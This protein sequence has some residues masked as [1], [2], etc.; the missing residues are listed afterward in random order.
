MVWAVPEAFHLHAFPISGAVFAPDI[1]VARLH[2]RIVYFCIL[3]SNLAVERNANGRR[4]CAV[5]GVLF[6]RCH[7]LT[8][9]LAGMRIDH[10]PVI[11][12]HVS[13][14]R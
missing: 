2:A 9:V 6:C 11:R 5:F 14:V 8:F 3:R 7:P 4:R 1:W 12:E 13:L 10:L